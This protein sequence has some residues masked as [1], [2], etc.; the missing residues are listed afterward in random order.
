MTEAIENRVWLDVKQAAQYLG[1]SASYIY[2]RASQ[3]SIPVSRSIGR[4]R[5]SRCKLDEWMEKVSS[6]E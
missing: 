6:R 3:N 5:F 1:C 2:H 4:L